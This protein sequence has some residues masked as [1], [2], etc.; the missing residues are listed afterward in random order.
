MVVPAMPV[1]GGLVM[2]TLALL[3]TTIALAGSAYEAGTPVYGVAE[4]TDIL[5]P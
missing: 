5:C 2:V 4:K 3:E 1:V